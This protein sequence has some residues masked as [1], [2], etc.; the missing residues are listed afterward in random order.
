MS[1]FTCPFCQT[2]TTHP[3]DV[4][5]RYCPVCSVFVDQV[6]EAADA[7]GRGELSEADLL[8][9]AAGTGFTVPGIQRALREG[10]G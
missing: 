3:V 8:R 5:E 2:T 1:G 6:S 9:L 10:R 7:V 4:A